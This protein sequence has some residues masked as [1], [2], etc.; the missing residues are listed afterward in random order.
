MKLKSLGWA[1]RVIG[2]AWICA[3][4]GAYTTTATDGAIFQQSG[5]LPDPASSALRASAARDLP[6]ESSNVEVRR[7]EPERKYA[8]TGC[9]WR[10]LYHVVTP[11]LTS[12]RIDLLSRTP[13]P[14][15]AETPQLTTTRAATPPTT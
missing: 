5:T 11:T 3:G 10:V 15:G 7:L 6:C 1:L 14:R 9:G 13:L 8:V 4:C 2:G 12:R